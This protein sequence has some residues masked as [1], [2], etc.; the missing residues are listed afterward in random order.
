MSFQLLGRDG[1]ARRGRL[2]LHRGSVETPVFMPVGTYGTVKAMT[3]AELERLGWEVLPSKANF[4]FARKTGIAGKEIYARLKEK[5]IL[6]RHFNLEGID[7][8]VR[9]TVGTRESLET[10]V[11][12]IKTLF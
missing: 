8:F 5:G 6:V 10:L 12:E 9:S 1:V 3:P 4:V 11:G 7:D 2:T